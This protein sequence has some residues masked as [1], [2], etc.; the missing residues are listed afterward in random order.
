MTQ[1]LVG[2][3]SAAHAWRSWRGPACDAAEAALHDV[4]ALDPGN[5]EAQHSL[6]VLHRQRRAQAG[7]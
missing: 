6:D 1:F 3:V 5:A 2:P 7:G 4:L